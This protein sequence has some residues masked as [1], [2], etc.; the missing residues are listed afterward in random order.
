MAEKHKHRQG[1]DSQSTAHE[2]VGKIHLVE[3]RVS[4]LQKAVRRPIQFGDLC[5]NFSCVS[6]SINPPGNSVPPHCHE[7]YEFLL[8]LEGKQYISVL[9][10]EH[11]YEE[12]YFTLMPPGVLHSHRDYPDLGNRGIVVRFTARRAPCADQAEPIAEKLLGILS[13]PHA[14][15]LID[16]GIVRL[17]T[18]P[19]ACDACVSLDLI[20]LIMRA[21]AAYAKD[22]NVLG[23]AIKPRVLNDRSWWTA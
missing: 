6:I 18:A 2:G 13:T 12:G 17:L 15:P 4:Q 14:A 20:T 7:F 23:R 11:L 3:Q 19:E 21:A 8:L 22:G 16:E 1:L 10:N 5:V 9:G